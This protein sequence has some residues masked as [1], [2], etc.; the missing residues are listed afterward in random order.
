MSIEVCTRCTRY[1]DTDED[2]DGVYPNGEYVCFSCATE[3][4]LHDDIMK[5]VARIEA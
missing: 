5:M 4:E 1:V 2:I 3:E